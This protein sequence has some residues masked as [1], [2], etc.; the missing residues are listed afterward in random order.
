VSKAGRGRELKPQIIDL[1]LIIIIWGG[2]VYSRLVLDINKWLLILIWLILS[3]FIGI[4]AVWPRKLVTI[5]PS[6]GQIQGNIPQNIFKKLWHSWVGFSRKLGEF[7]SRLIMSM[8][9]FILVSPLAPFVKIFSDPLR[10]KKFTKN[11]YW[12]PRAKSETDLEH[13]RRQG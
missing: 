4:L 3:F 8:L 5:K 2:A 1:L 13:F 12:L 10:T 9:F 11:S 6:G 7:Q